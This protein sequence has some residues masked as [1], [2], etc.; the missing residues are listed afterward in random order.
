MAY[1]KISELPVGQA[2][3]PISGVA[4]MDAVEIGQTSP[5][6]GNF[7]TMTASAIAG[8][9]TTATQAVGD[10][11]TKL[12][13][14]AF[15][16]TAISNAVAGV[17]PAV[18]V[19]AATVNAANTSALTYNNGAAGVGAT[20]TG[21][22]NTA[23][24]IDGYT[25]TATGQRLL[26]KNDTQSPSGAFNGI[27]YLTQ[28]QT[29]ILAPIFTRALD[30]NS[31]SNMND[32]GA[33]P[34][35]NGTANALTSWLLT[36][37]VVT[38]GT[39]P[40]TYGQFSINPSSIVST[41][42]VATS[43]GFAGN[44]SGGTTPTLTLSTTI[45]GIIKGNGTALAAATVGTDYSTGTAGLSTG[46]LKSTTATGVLSIAKSADLPGNVVS[47][48]TSTLN[49]ITCDLSVTNVFKHTFTE[50]TTF[51]FSNPTATGNQCAFDLWLFQGGTPYVP[52]W[53]AAVAWS[54]ATPPVVNNANKKYRINFATIDGGTIWV[55]TLTAE[56]YA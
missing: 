25:F 42:A 23:I 7:T 32:T 1:T 3:S 10:N 49:A 56:A 38:V 36:S 53:P 50:N 33:I 21:T 24:T 11:S 52:T 20:L 55:G 48:V 37:N 41:V 44:S 9:P 16:A 28:L 27:Y 5:Q 26:V 54:N 12:A 29:G 17:N 15:T 18:A 8:N 34:V 13:T 35:V 39:S 51:T 45:S 6:V 40:L 22:V 14:T 47:V 4:Y 30:Y 46:V 43:N 31:P 2:I 19:E